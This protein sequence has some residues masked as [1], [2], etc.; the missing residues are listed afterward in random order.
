MEIKT[1]DWPVQWD[2]GASNL[3]TFYNL[4]EEEFKI[5]YRV[6]PINSNFDNEF[7]TFIFLNCQSYKFHKMRFD[8][9]AL[10]KHKYF[11][12]G[13][14]HYRAHEIKDSDWIKEFKTLNPDD[15]NRELNHYFLSFKD[16]I[17][18]VLAN[19]FRLVE[20]GKK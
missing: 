10:Q 1:I 11:N 19:G 17:L 16:E 2:I 4:D 7:V 15:H 6:A 12:L 14:E 13:L 18:E 9:N 20:R 5:T 8:L 3:E